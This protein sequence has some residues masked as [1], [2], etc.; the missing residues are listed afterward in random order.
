M[1]VSM[2]IEPVNGDGYCAHGGSPFNLIARGATREEAIRNLRQ[3]IGERVAVGT[4]VILMEV[5]T[6][7]PWF[8]EVG[9][10]DPNDPLVKEWEAAMAENRRAADENMDLP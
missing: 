3:E 8:N 5:P 9:F 6:G 10:L 2:L 7:N 4:E 1:Q